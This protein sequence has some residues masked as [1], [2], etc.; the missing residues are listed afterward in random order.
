MKNSSATAMDDLVAHYDTLVNYIS[1]KLGNR[2]AAFE[3]VQETYLRVLQRPE[4]FHNLHSPL[5]FLKKVSMNIAL[6]YLKKNKNDAQYIESV[7]DLD[8][9]SDAEAH[10]LSSQELSL[11]KKQYGQLILAHI[12]ALPPMCQ[13]VFLL[14]QFYGMTQV[15]IAKQLGISRMMVIKHLTR[16]LQSFLPIFIEEQ[17]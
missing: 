9:F 16:A 14:S 1:F 13:D 17:R 5:A 11:V 12:A 4:Q 3:I 6:D 7:E 8:A 10:L 2:Q 15:D